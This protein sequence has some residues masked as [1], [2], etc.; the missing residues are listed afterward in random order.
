MLHYSALE[1]GNKQMS[2]TMLALVTDL[3]SFI[4]NNE[5]GLHIYE[6]LPASRNIC[7]HWKFQWRNGFPTW[8]C[9]WKKNA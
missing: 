7:Q 6:E 3:T 8:R 4:E 5:G 1:F 2:E 9:C